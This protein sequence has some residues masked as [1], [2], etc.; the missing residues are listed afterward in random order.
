MKPYK[1]PRTLIIWIVATIKRL[2]TYIL[3]A[4]ILIRGINNR[5]SCA[6]VIISLSFKD[7]LHK[8]PDDYA[9]AGFTI[10]HL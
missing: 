2:R 6:I 3:V 10:I 8:E 4:S 9:P 7:K 1:R 5:R